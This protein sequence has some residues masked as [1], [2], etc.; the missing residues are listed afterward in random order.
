VNIQEDAAFKVLDRRIISQLIELGFTLKAVIDFY[1]RDGHLCGIG[2]P[3][4]SY[5]RP[6]YTEEINCLRAI[7]P[8][9]P[10]PAKNTPLLECVTSVCQMLPEFSQEER[11]RLACVRGDALFLN[12]KASYRLYRAAQISQNLTP[13]SSAEITNCIGHSQE[14][15][16]LGCRMID[17]HKMWGLSMKFIQSL[18]LLP[19]TSILKSV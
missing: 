3:A 6:I 12:A 13:V 19:K 11:A 10:E 4:A 7:C 8:P 14:P 17:D 16:W 2:K 15:Y 18:G 1:H 5:L 9:K